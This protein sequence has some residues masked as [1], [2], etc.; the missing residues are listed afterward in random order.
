MKYYA[1]FTTESGDTVYI[2]A[3]KYTESTAAYRQA[4][5]EDRW[6]DAER[7]ETCEFDGWM[8]ETEYFELVGIE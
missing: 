4:V 6:D 5:E 8:T 2:P 7:Y 1:A 3:D